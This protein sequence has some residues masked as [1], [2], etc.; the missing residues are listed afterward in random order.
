MLMHFSDL[1]FIWNLSTQAK[2][3]YLDLEKCSVSSQIDS[4]TSTQGFPID[5]APSPPLHPRLICILSEP[6]KCG[7]K[8]RSPGPVFTS[9]HNK[10]LFRFRVYGSPIT[11]LPVLNME[12]DF[13]NTSV[14]CC[15]FYQCEGRASTWDFRVSVQLILPH[16]EPLNQVQE[17]KWVFQ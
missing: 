2:I 3:T 5:S 17:G 6:S 13:W 4:E 16:P 9:V 11:S 7:R 10:P 1:T 8:P 15:V 12:S 14:Y